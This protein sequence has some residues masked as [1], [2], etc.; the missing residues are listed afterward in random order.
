MADNHVLKP[1]PAVTPQ[2]VCEAMGLNW[3]VALTLRQGG[4]LS[5]APENPPRLN[6]AQET[7]LRFLGSLVIGGCD[8]A[9]QPNSKTICVD[10]ARR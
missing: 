3:D 7:E 6:K 2:A 8:P 1:A 9:Q 5:F 10:Q 4:C